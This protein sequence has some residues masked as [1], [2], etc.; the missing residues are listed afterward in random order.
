MPSLHSTQQFW[1]IPHLPYHRTSEQLLQCR[2][3]PCNAHPLIIHRYNI[4]QHHHTRSSFPSEH[5][6]NS[7]Y[8]RQ[9]APYYYI[10]RHLPRMLNTPTSLALPRHD[11]LAP[12]PTVGNNGIISWATPYLPNNP[13]YLPP[14]LTPSFLGTGRHPHKNYTNINLARLWTNPPAPNIPCKQMQQFC[15]LHTQPSLP[16]IRL[17]DVPG[18]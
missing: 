13:P 8:I 17:W 1:S 12:L 2:H 16:T 9:M 5:G 18:L 7:R 6:F 14:I 3:R 15:T 4:P 11:N 10:Y